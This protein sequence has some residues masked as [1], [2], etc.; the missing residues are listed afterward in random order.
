M[1]GIDFILGKNI[2]IHKL[3]Y[4]TII[5]RIPNGI[6]IMENFDFLFFILWF[7]VGK[8]NKVNVHIVAANGVLINEKWVFISILS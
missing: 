6:N 5:Y 1:N 4:T 7:S 8:G 2:I 3:I